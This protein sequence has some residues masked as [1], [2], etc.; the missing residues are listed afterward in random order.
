VLVHCSDGWDRTAGLTSLAQMVIDPYYRTLQGF[1]VL[2][3]K[4]W[5]AFGHRFAKRCGT[6]GCGYD[7]AHHEDDQRAPIFL[8]WVDAVWQVWRQAPGAFE[9]NERLLVALA[10]HAYSGRFGTFLLDCERDRAEARLSEGTVS[11][12]TY[13]L[14]AEHRGG[15]TNP[16]YSPL[17]PVAAVATGG[18]AGDGPHGGTTYTPLLGP[19][20][21]PP[22]QFSAGVESLVLWPHWLLRWP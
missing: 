15:F 9:F 6:G 10:E 5:C 20:A 2:V 12:W 4:E 21:V 22:L 14:A 13:V 19:L 3:E 8:Q 16:G 11:L 18:D 17:R 1:A 7:R